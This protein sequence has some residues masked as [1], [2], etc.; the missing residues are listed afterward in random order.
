MIPEENPLPLIVW[1]CRSI[2]TPLAVIVMQFVFGGAIM[3]WVT[4]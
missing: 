4:V 3:F 2:A 1:P